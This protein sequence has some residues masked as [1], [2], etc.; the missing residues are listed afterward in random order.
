[1]IGVNFG[2]M[3]NTLRTHKFKTGSLGAKIGDGLVFVFVAGDVVG[4]IGLHVLETEGFV[5]GSY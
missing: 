5:H 3:F 1:M 4:K 2:V